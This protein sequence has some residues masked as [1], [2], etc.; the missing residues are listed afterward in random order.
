MIESILSAANKAN[1]EA[2]QKDI[3]K[4]SHYIDLMLLATTVP[5]SHNSVHLFGQLLDQAR[6]Q[7][8]DCLFCLLSQTIKTHCYYCQAG[9]H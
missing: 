9:T 3:H 6:L 4:Y 2:R 7:F 1:N 5:F 8:C